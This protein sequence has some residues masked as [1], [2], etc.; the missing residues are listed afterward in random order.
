VNAPQLRPEVAERLRGR[1][2]GF[3]HT[4]AAPL[5]AEFYAQ[6]VLEQLAEAPCARTGCGHPADV[7]GAP[8]PFRACPECG[9]A[10]YARGG[11]LVV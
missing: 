6:T 11:R 4:Y 2:Y 3:L 8:T 9:C 7:H 1:P 10:G 5:T